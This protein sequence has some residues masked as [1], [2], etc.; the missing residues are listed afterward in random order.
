VESG[1]NEQHIQ[2]IVAGTLAGMMSSGD[3]VS[4]PVPRETPMIGEEMPMAAPEMP[5]Q[6]GEMQ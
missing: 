6:G 2:D 4:E 5:M 3:L 1:L